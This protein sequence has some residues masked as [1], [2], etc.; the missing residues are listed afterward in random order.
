[1]K[2]AQIEG[3]QA[4]NMHEIATAFRPEVVIGEKL[5]LEISKEGEHGKKQGV[6]FLPDGTMVVVENAANR[7]GE[8]IG[9][10]V[11][12]SV[13]TSSGKMIFAKID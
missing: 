4:L 10:E 5:E 6:G 13:Q 1:M 3:V 2:V 7:I 12:N 9:V 8:T 11:T